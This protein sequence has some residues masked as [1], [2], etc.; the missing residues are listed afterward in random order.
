[1][2]PTS[3]EIIDRMNEE[4]TEDGD[5]C[6]RDGCQGYIYE[7]HKGLRCGMCAWEEGYDDD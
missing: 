1:M 5:R 7:S 6:N 2:T 4:G 3:D